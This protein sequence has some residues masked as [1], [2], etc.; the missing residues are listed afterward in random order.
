MWLPY[1]NLLVTTLSTVLGSMSVSTCQQYLPSVISC[2]HDVRTQT[3]GSGFSSSSHA[4]G[5]SHL[6]SDAYLVRFSSVLLLYLEFD[7]CAHFSILL[8]SFV[9]TGIVH[10]VFALVS[11]NWDRN[12][13]IRLRTIKQMNKNSSTKLTIRLHETSDE[14]HLF[15]ANFACLGPKH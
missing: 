1:H 9:V 12:D 4:P 3:T 5:S 8:L 10:A 7:W 6:S 13:T 15:F 2:A 14:L 11:A